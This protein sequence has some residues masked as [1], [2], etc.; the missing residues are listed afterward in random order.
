[1]CGIAGFIDKGRAYDAETSTRIATAMATTLRHRGPDDAGAWVDP[2]AGVA[3]AH[4]RLSI[5]DLSPAGHQP[6]TSS[7]GRWVLTFNGEIYN[8]VELRDELAAL[9]RT[10]RGHS[11]TE[12]LVEA[13]ATWGVEATL[14]LVV[15]AIV[16]SA[17]TGFSTCW[18][19]SVTPKC[20]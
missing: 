2:S 10:F 18:A 15:R 8:F 20:E 4:R 7:C 3:L 13:C 17:G 9:G 5:V 6:M 16:R 12:V 14:R 1:M 11:D 19:S